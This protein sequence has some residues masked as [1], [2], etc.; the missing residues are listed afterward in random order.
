MQAMTL[1]ELQTY[2][3][4]LP[5]DTSFIVGLG[6]PFIINN[7]VDD[8][9][10][11]AKLFTTA[12]EQ[13]DLID[14]LLGLELTSNTGVKSI[15]RLDTQYVHLGLDVHSTTLPLN[16][17]SLTL[18]RA[19]SKD[20]KLI[21]AKPNRVASLGIKPYYEFEVPSIW[22]DSLSTKHQHELLAEH[23]NT[24]VIGGLE[25]ELID[26]SKYRN[27]DHSVTEGSKWVDENV[28]LKPNTKPNTPR[29]EDGVLVTDTT[30]PTESVWV[31]E[32]YDSQPNP[33][34]PP[35]QPDLNSTPLPFTG[36][37]LGGF[38]Q[39]VSADIL[40]PATD[41]PAIDPREIPSN[42]TNTIP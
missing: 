37:T 1:R 36:R 42:V 40:I 21:R 28:A 30:P 31:D 5:A 35:V 4:L 26:S 39:P 15:V 16:V 20:R 27:K 17:I 6:F 25:W 9:V 22:W 33:T 23:F 19:H 13:M 41:I 38:E 29:Y 8:L 24:T 34:P 12:R 2:F 7:R 3:R 18:L 14:M 11:K 10:F 32:L